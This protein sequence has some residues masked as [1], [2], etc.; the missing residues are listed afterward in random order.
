MTKLRTLYGNLGPTSNQ[1][2]APRTIAFRIAKRN[3][4]E[5]SVTVATSKDSWVPGSFLQQWVM[6][7]RAFRFGNNGRQACKILI[8]EVDQVVGSSN[9][10]TKKEVLRLA[11]NGYIARDL[12]VLEAQAFDGKS[13]ETRDRCWRCRLTFGFTWMSIEAD[14]TT[15]TENNLRDFEGRWQARPSESGSLNVECVVFT[16]C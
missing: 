6:E 11:M 8:N 12:R 16:V 10:D 3:S 9:Q 2:G 13:F 14:P 1:D 4:V 15:E 7:T 5:V